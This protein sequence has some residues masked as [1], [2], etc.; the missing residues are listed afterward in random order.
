MTET[1]EAYVRFWN[2]EPGEPQRR[3]GAQV[4]T[5]DV[6]AGHHGGAA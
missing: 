4:F 5:P 6:P 3:A 2:T 1:I